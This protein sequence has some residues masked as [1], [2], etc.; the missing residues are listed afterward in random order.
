MLRGAP[1]QL[2]WFARVAV[3]GGLLALIFR[4]VPINNVLTQFAHVRPLPL[5]V[6]VLA[7]LLGRL[8]AAVQFKYLTDAQHMNVSLGRIFYIN[9]ATAFYQLFL[10]GYISGGA[11]RWYKLA[12]RAD[13][14][15]KALSVI[16]VSRLFDSMV[17]VV[18]MLVLFAADAAAW[19]EGYPDAVKLLVGALVAVPLSCLFLRYQQRF[20]GVLHNHLAGSGNA[21]PGMPGRVAGKVANALLGFNWLS[22]RQLLV[23]AA[24][25]SLCHVLGAL[26][27]YYMAIGLGIDVPLLSI[28]WIR[29]FIYLAMLIPVSISGLGV[30][31]GLLI[32]L[33]A[34]LGIA[35]SSAVALALLLL[36]LS[37]AIGL[38]GGVLEAIVIA[39][40]TPA[41][42]CNKP[43]T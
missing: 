25:L 37:I 6:A 16:V 28:V 29:I 32:I 10:P 17:A 27:W 2:K 41:E 20:G 22:T 19:A 7:T 3:A 5:L 39:L 18:W 12:A 4:Y 38:L 36:F 40:G 35:S 26:S 14:S 24:L 11:V 9:T 30:R 43:A 21:Y 13:N 42:R 1:P 8:V 23:T 33:L 34:P 15:D 31:E